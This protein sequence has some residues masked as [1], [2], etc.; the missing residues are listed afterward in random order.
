[1]DRRVTYRVIGRPQPRFDAVDKIRGATRYAADWQLP[2][3]L[4]GAVLRSQHPAARIRR[5]DVA[6]A[7]AMPGVAAVLTA[8]DVPHNAV[9]EDPTGIGLIRFATPV[10][11]DGQVRYQGEPI[12][13]VAAESPA[14]AQTALETIEIEYEPLPGLFDAADALR[15]GAPRVHDGRDNVLVHWTLRRGDVADGFRRA[16]AVVERTYRTQR[17]DHAYL[18][19]EAG[20]AWIDAQGVV[21]IR[22][23]SQVIE[24]FREIAEM[25]GVPHNRVRVVAPFLGGGFGGK[26]DM[27]VEPYLALLA[28][29]T[30]QPVR[31]A[32]SRYDSLLARPKRHPFTMRYKTGAARDGRLV[33]QEISLVADAGPYP[34]LSPR[35][36]FAA[37]VTGGGPY[38]IPNVSIDARAVFT[39][40]VPS[41]AMRGFGAMQV[42][43]AY[44]SQMDA[45]AERLGLTPEEI[46]ARNFLAKGDR[47]PTGESVETHVALPELVRRATAAL[48]ERG[49]PSGPSAR[50]G[51][52]FACNI[53]PYGRTVW[54]RDRASAWLGFEADGSL[55]IRSGVPDLG[56]GQSAVLAQIAAEVLGVS[57]DRVTVHVGDSALTPLAGGTFATRQLYMSGNA[58][59]QGAR[60]LRAQVAP[61][62][63]ALLEAAE[64]DLEFADDHI[65][66]S[67]SPDRRIALATMVAECGRRGV[68]AAHLATFH[69][70]QAP[71]VELATGQGRTFPDFTYGCHAAEVEVDTET[72]AVRLLK[73]AAC[74]DVGQAINP[75]S[76]EGQIQGGAAMGIGQALTEEVVV[77]NGNNLST[78]FAGYLIPTALDLP[79]VQAVIVESGEG[80]GPFGARG[81]GEP[82]T[83]PPPAAIASA[84]ENATGARLR[85]LPMTPER[86]LRALDAQQKNT[87]GER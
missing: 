50:I 68:S 33:A 86:V 26:E 58:A 40:N 7:R 3:M 1:M 27:T 24:H 44:E 71:P 8:H 73:Y 21:N 78:L 62:A 75:Q 84:I 76:V 11:A 39:N 82:P 16:D 63:A 47:L 57:L 46:R 43:F 52:G 23:S 6:R 66:V 80:K 45:L 53:Q 18:E 31:M 74:H 12:A 10:L 14:L 29:T 51:R 72:G 65:S 2:G 4:A 30:G 36:L 15:P 56:G 28:W 9:E 38:K 22:A 60:E 19:P 54:F 13:L 55:V 41:S 59:L 17:V 34:L 77:E 5:L 85:E 37:L 42:T 32:W 70:E 83:G 48:G 81:I 61:V 64:A 20:V 69:A 25:L 87:E 67:G 35:V 79:D 49:R